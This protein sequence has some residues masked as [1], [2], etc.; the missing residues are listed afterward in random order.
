MIHFEFT[1][2]CGV[3]RWSSFIL[4]TYLS[5]FP[6]TIY[7][8]NYL[9]STACVCFSTEYQLTIKVWVY[10]WVLYPVPLTYVSDF[11]PVPHSFDHYVLVAQCDI[12]SVIP[13]TLFFFFRIDIAMQGHL[14]FHINFLNI[15]SSSVKYVI[16][17]LIGIT[18]NL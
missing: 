18:L 6:N 10:F 1:L 9:S 14:W 17:I 13:P 12:S 15:W 7:W 2:V 8:I 5:N 11:M 3:R 16:G 4:C